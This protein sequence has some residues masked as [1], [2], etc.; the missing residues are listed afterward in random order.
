MSLTIEQIEQWRV[1]LHNGGQDLVA[2]LATPEGQA[3]PE[4]NLLTRVAAG[5]SDGVKIL[6]LIQAKRRIRELGTTKDA[7]TAEA[8]QL[9][10]ELTP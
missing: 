7:L 2:Y 3:D 6:R 4:I 5:L 9:I 8:A 10:A 1:V